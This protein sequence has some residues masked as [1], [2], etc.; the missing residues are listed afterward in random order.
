MCFPFWSNSYLQISMPTYS[1]NGPKSI[2]H[3]SLQS[4][5]RRDI[6]DPQYMNNVYP[7]IHSICKWYERAHTETQIT[8]L[9]C[10]KSDGTHKALWKKI[11]YRGQVS[12]M[13]I[14]MIWNNPTCI[15]VLVTQRDKITF[16]HLYRYM[17]VY[18][19]NSRERYNVWIC[20]TTKQV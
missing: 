17:A 2:I 10:F 7:S 6:L 18:F 14:Q 11:L 19:A 9:G 16:L 15:L 3:V 8:K 20:V 13:R 12:T 1:G 4:F 5:E